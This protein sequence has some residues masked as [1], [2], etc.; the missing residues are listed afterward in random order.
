M[1]GRR[2]ARSI[3]WCD[4]RDTT[5]DGRTKGSIE[6]DLP[7]QGMAGMPPFKREWK[8]HASYMAPTSKGGPGSRRG[9]PAPPFGVAARGEMSAFMFALRL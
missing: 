4:A 1:M 5:A 7:L 3:Q 8:T 9:G 2:I 6:L